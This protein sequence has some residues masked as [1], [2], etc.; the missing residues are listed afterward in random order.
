[1]NTTEVNHDKFLND[2]ENI[3][4]LMNYQGI[5]CFNYKILDGKPKIFEINPRFGGTM[6]YFI[7][8]GIH[9]YIK[10]TSRA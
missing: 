8:Q 6:P 2:F 3:L 4:S 1:M 10:A 5:C 7:D 9:S